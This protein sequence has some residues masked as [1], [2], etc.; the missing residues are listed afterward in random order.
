MLGALIALPLAAGCDGCGKDKPYTPFGVASGLPSA[1]AEADAGPDEP[2]AGLPRP[3]FVVRVASPAP[4]RATRWSLDG[5]ELAAPAGRVFERGIAADFD[6][7][8]TRESVVWTLP[9]AATPPAPAGELWLFPSAG[10][11][12]KLLEL[13]GFVP[14]GPACK[15]TA[16]LL[17]TGP[18]SVTLDVSASCTTTLLARAPTRSVSVVAP[19]SDRPHVL[20]LRVAAAFPTEPFALDVDSTD[21]DGDGRDDVRLVVTQRPP[22]RTDPALVAQGCPTDKDDKSVSVQVVWI[23]RAA[24]LS[25]DA[26]EPAASLGALA[27]AELGRSKRKQTAAS[28]PRGVAQLRRLLGTLCAEGAAS[29]LFEA[30]G[31]M[32]RCEP[33]GT[34]VE[35]LLVAEVQAAL[36][37]KDVERALAALDRDGWYFGRVPDKRR[38]ELVKSVSADTTSVE[39]KVTKLAV[40]PLPRGN[41]PRLSPLAFESSGALLVQTSGGLSRIGESGTAEPVEPDADLGAWPLAIETR[42]GQRLEN[43]VFPCDRSDVYLN[44]A[45]GQGAAV[46]A[47]PSSLLSPRPGA[48]S[49]GKAPEAS[50]IALGEKDDRLSL[51]V[52]GE[53]FGPRISRA[54]AVLRPRL[55]GTPRSPDGR[56]LVVPTSLGL[57]VEGGDK[58][59]LWRV[60]DAGAWSECTVADG[61]KAVA[62]VSGAEVVLLRR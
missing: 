35:R 42:G 18:K 21:R 31:S 45:S 55:L 39:P 43:V 41:A 62:C 61:A 48:C 20:T 38:A 5:R 24:G 34:V 57:L 22:C 7:D 23:D 4:D 33:L 15:H 25:R 47:L 9:A 59:E 60:K 52:A 51:L 40:S 56:H 13:P 29:R 54:E 50:I 37:E 58:P 14:T 12:R 49:G 11:P 10:A 1:V 36:T 32:L 26:T 44:V 8:G 19:L 6:G 46:S 17:Q 53:S 16:A 30:D 28:V 2:D 27:A 3:K